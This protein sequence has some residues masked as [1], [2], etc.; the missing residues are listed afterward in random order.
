M[1]PPPFLIVD[2]IIWIKRGGKNIMSSV[3]KTLCHRPKGQDRPG[4]PE[5]RKDHDPVGLRTQDS[6]FSAPEVEA[7]G[8]G[9][10]SPAV[11][12]CPDRSGHLHS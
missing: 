3:R 8:S 9:R 11:F 5:G 2:G 10:S 12:R 1:V 7:T 6:L 4:N